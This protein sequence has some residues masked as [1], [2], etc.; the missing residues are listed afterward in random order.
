[1]SARGL[2]NVLRA[3]PHAYTHPDEI[4]RFAE[5]LARAIH[6]LRKGRGPG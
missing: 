3:A 5:A 1:M 2:S 6:D 4:A